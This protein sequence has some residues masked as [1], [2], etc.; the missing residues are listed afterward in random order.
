MVT[1]LRVLLWAWNLLWAALSIHACA[2][3]SASTPKLESTAEEIG[4]NTGLAI[5]FGLIFWVWFLGF[6]V[7]AIGYLITKPRKVIIIGQEK[8]VTI[9]QDKPLVTRQRSQGEIFRAMAKAER[10][11]DLEELRRL[12]EEIDEIRMREKYSQDRGR[13]TA[14]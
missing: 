12:R 14:S 9:D 7:L 3:V 8:P 1:V 6:I 13:N 10:D 11:G 4:W 5:G 2:N